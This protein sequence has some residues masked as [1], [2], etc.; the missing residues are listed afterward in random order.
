MF[1]YSRSSHMY[2]VWMSSVGVLTTCL[3]LSFEVKRSG[4]RW[5]DKK[6]L[7]FFSMLT[8]L[9]TFIMTRL[10]VTFDFQCSIPTAVATNNTISSCSI[11]WTCFTHQKT[12]WA[13][14][15]FECWDFTCWWYISLALASLH[16]IL[17]AEVIGRVSSNTHYQVIRARRILKC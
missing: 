15:K 16:T 6:A 14:V 11:V 9:W 13:H 7:H 10:G 12:E 8:S 5:W 3:F 1:L 2:H 17:P 4:R